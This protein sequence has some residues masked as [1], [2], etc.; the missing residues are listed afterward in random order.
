MNFAQRLRQLDRLLDDNAWLWRPQPFKEARPG[1]CHDVPELCEALRALSDSELQRLSQDDAALRSLLNRYLPELEALWPLTELPACARRD[2]PGPGPHFAAGI[3]G[4]KWQQI[5]AFSASLAEVKAPLLEWCGGKGHLG[6]LLARQ[7]QQPVLTLELEGELCEQGEALAT[8]VG[9]DQQFYQGDALQ[10]AV[11]TVLANRHAVALHACGELHRTLIRAGVE[12]KVPSMDIA[13]CCYH[14]HGKDTYEPL[15]E[16]LRLHLSRDDMRIAVTETVTAIGRE[17]RQRDTEMA[18]KLAFNAL[19]SDLSG[20][21]EYRPLKPIDKRWLKYG[22]SG[23]CQ[24][25]AQREGV[26][27]P[28][29]GVDWKRYEEAGWRRQRETM[30]LSLV[31]HAFRRAIEMWLMLDLANYLIRHGYRVS[32]GTFCGRELTPRNILISAR[33][34]EG[35]N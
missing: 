13:P 23:F 30:R 29:E 17:V 27:L 33:R 22:F 18:W 16:G 12:A 28:D 24:A 19:R 35:M 34:E 3:P 25:L 9:V 26:V 31:R 5:D 14:L 15:S 10:P 4:R 32:L 7:W 1:W 6:R 21:R 11:K 2:L 20:D 8:R